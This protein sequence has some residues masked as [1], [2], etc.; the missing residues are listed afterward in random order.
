MT[1]RIDRELAGRG[2]ARSRSHARQLLDAGVVL[3]NGHPCRRSSALV[4]ASDRI[5]LT[6]TD[7]YVSRAAH[8][9]LGA[10]KDLDVTV[11]G[12]ALDAGASTGGFTQVLLESGCDRVYAVDVGHAQLDARLRD[13][14]RV[15]SR[16]GVNLKDLD[17]HLLD[18]QQVQLIVADVSF[19]SLCKLLDRL[20]GVLRPD[21]ELLA[22]VKPQF[23]VGQAQVGRDGAV[24]SPQLRRAAVSDVID[25]AGGHGLR[26]TGVVSSRVPGPAGNREFFCRFVP[27]HCSAWPVPQVGTARGIVAADLDAVDWRD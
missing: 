27:D 1:V 14:P 11:G 25:S 13:D 15:R 19:I 26:A 24:R 2:L 7:R 22:M 8:K 23:E 3:L 20:T 16:E 10:L 6:A 4:A 12:R 5:R 18:G 9:L 21:G 17:L